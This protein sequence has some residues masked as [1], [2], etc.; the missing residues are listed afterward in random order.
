MGKPTKEGIMAKDRLSPEQKAE[1]VILGIGNAAGV[2]KL[3][4]QYGMHPR[5]FYRQK[6]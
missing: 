5:L 3:R 6:K 2:S 1:L 4:R